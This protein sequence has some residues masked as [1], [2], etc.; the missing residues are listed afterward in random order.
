MRPGPDLSKGRYFILLP[1]LPMQL[2]QCNGNAASVDSGAHNVATAAQGHAVSHGGDSGLHA[3]NP[4]TTAQAHAVGGDS[5]PPAH[6]MDP[7]TLFLHFQLFSTLGLS[8]KYPPIYQ[9]STVNFTWSNFILP[10]AV[11]RN[12]AKWMRKCDLDTSGNSASS[13]L[14]V[15][16]VSNQVSIGIY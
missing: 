10:L 2:Q 11:F 13:E 3:H 16:P 5:G 12:A 9:A 14:S 6:N 4:A 8:L 1:H 7:T 15:P